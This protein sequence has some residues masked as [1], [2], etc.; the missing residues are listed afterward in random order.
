MRRP[1]ERRDTELYCHFH[2]DHGHTTEEC[3]VF[4]GEIKNLIVKGHLKQFI[5]TNDRQQNGRRVNQRRIEEAPLKDPPVINTTSEKSSTKGLSNSSRKA[6]A[7][8][9]NLTQGPA[10]RAKVSTTLES[11][12]NIIFEDAFL[13]M[14]I[15]KDQV[16]PISSFLYGFTGAS[17]P[18]KGITSLTI[19]AG[20]SPGV[21]HI[22]SALS[23]PIV[24]EELFLYLDVAE[25]AVNA[26][27]IREQEGRQLPIYYVSKVL[28]EVELR[29]PNAEKLV[30]ALLIVTR[31]LQP[32]FQSHTIIVLT[33]KPLRRILHKPELSGCLVPWLVELDEF[34]IQY[35]PQPSIKGHALVDFIVECTLPIED[36]EPLPSNQPKFTW[37]LF[38]DGSSNTNESGVGLILNGLDGLTIETEAL[39]HIE[40]GLTSLQLT[41]HD[42]IQNE[43]ALRANLDLLNDRREQA[44]MPSQPTNIEYPN[45]MTRESALVHSRWAT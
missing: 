39:I 33:D 23:K 41:T 28:Q 11:S 36:K 40:V 37:T 2:K 26:V 15:L 20:E 35:R 44:T 32:Y 13:Q 9:V 17:A 27:L 21:F 5:K 14:E 29:Y 16:K 18:L 25:S 7:R 1:A 3:K 8:Q 43:E 6:Y 12:A 42:P 30:F 31:K 24:G 22:T 38:V 4:Q 10:K 19:I 34:D 45:F